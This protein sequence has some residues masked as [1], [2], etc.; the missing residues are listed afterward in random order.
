MYAVKNNNIGTCTSC[1]SLLQRLGFTLF[2]TK[3]RRLL[4]VG[5]AFLLRV[6]SFEEVDI[7][8]LIIITQ[9]LFFSHFF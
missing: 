1:P 7:L 2:T 8:G 6:F 5:S 4:I 9:L 3:F